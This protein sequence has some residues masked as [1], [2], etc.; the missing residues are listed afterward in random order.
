MPKLIVK[1]RN[2]EEAVIDATAGISVMEALRNDGI[3]ELQAI[4]GGCCSCATCHVYVDPG[5]LA[6]LPPLT[7]VENE[8]LE[9]SSHRQ[10]N[11][12]LSCQIVV[13]ESLGELRVTV[14]PE[15]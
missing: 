7:G 1:K 4:C 13:D 6:K 10:E 2:G 15:D 8:L 5:S 11:S 14:A 12:R 3:D 9:C